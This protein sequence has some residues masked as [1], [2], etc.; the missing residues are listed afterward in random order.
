MKRCCVKY[1]WRT[2]QALPHPSSTHEKLS[3]PVHTNHHHG[4]SAEIKSFKIW[5]LHRIFK[6][7]AIHGK[8]ESLTV[9]RLTKNVYSNKFLHISHHVL[10]SNTEN[11]ISGQVCY[12]VSIFNLCIFFHDPTVKS[13]TI[14]DPFHDPE[15]LP[16]IH[17]PSSLFMTWQKVETL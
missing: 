2:Y 5:F 7:T 6:I 3:C 17:D 16:K 1:I 11:H 9:L 4:C 13:Q 15:T 10:Y 12:T 8:E 14:P